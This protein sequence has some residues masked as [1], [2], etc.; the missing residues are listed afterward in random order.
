MIKGLFIA[1]SL[2]TLT[3]TCGAETPAEPPST[4]TSPVVPEIASPGHPN[5]PAKTLGGREFWGDVAFCHGWRIQQN[6]FTEHFRLLDPSDVRRGWGTCA[7]C[8]TK[9]EAERSTRGLKPMSGKAVILI[10]GIGRSSKSMLPLVKPLQ[11]DGYTVVPFDYPSTRVSI[12]ESA[13]YL[14][15]VVRSLD[16]IEQI[17]FVVHSMGGLVVR[18]L[19]SDEKPDPRFRRMVMLGVPNRGAEMASLVED[20]P[21]FRLVYGKAGQQLVRDREG[22]I[23][24]LPTPKFEFAIIAGARGTEEGFNLLI[25]GDDDGTVTVA[26]TRLPGAT[27][28]M[29]VSAIHTLLMGNPAAIGATRRFLKQGTLR[30]EGPREPV[31]VE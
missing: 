11:E 20:Q 7:E 12:P 6:V 2:V 27:D 28:F 25:P 23:A 8:E 3:T 15:E 18:S 14:R 17:D 13:A 22:F 1:M 9:L 5:V 19:L 29:T 10:H 16:G 31:A 24:G 26:S 4:N 21:L 30:A